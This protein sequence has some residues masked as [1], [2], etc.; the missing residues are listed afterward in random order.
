M[1]FEKKWLASIMS[2]LRETLSE[3]KVSISAPWY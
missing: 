3:G 2:K 1:A